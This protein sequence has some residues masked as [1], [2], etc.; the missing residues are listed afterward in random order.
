MS[1]KVSQNVKKN[2]NLVFSHSPMK[3]GFPIPI[4]SRRRNRLMAPLLVL[5]GKNSREK[6]LSPDAT[7][8]WIFSISV[9]SRTVSP[10]SGGVG[11][12]DLHHENKLNLKWQSRSL[13]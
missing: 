9:F 10:V 3:S 11:E 4:L 12:T 6:N 13:G 8:E 7:L 5:G 2:Y 1:K